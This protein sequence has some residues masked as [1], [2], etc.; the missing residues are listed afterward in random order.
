MGAEP[1]DGVLLMGRHS[2]GEHRVLRVG[3]GQSAREHVFYFKMSAAG[4]CESFYR[5]RMR[6]LK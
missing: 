1:H 2:S 3:K 6:S 5:E 4:D